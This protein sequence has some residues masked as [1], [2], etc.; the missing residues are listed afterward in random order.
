MQFM[1][2]VTSLCRS[3]EQHFLYRFIVALIMES[4][5]V[6]LRADHQMNI[7]TAGLLQDSYKS[8]N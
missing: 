1:T 2:D 5:R 3:A 8:Q 6:G 4:Q 7:Y